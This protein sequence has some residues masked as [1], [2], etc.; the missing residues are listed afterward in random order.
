[1]SGSS[2]A[3]FRQRVAISTDALPWVARGGFSERLLELAP[4]RFTALFQLPAGATVPL[5]PDGYFDLLILDGALRD[6]HGRHPAR[7]FIR[8]RAGTVLTSEAATVLIKQR[9]HGRPPP[10]R[11]DTTRSPFRPSYDGY[12]GVEFADLIRDDTG[13]VVLMRLVP[14][15]SIPTHRHDLG[16]EFFVLAG[17]LT[18]ERGTYSAG[19]WVRQPPLSEHSITSEQGALTFIFAHHLA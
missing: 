10:Q 16:E 14:D 13:A 6:L 3:D 18:D 9:F 15:A 8:D 1:M 12:V 5:A 17:S 11:T 4:D 19:D 7:T 2:N